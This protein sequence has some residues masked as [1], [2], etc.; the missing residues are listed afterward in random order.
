MATQSKV[1]LADQLR[2][3][4]AGIKA[5]LTDV[6]NMIVGGTTMT[7]ADV[8]AKID[9]FLA[10]QTNTVNTKNGY[11]AA[12]VAEQASN[13]A[14]RTFRTQL[15]GYVVLRY[16]KANPILSQFGF[17][18]LKAKKTTTAVKAVAVLKVKA[19]RA[20]RHTMGKVQKK[21]IKGV[22]DPSVAEALAAVAAAAKAGEATDMQLTTTSGGAAEGQQGTAAPIVATPALAVAAHPAMPAPA[23]APAA[24]VPVA[25]TSAPTGEV[26][27]GG[28]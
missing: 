2:T 15:E 23:A 13:V 25:S 12:V 6:Q 19:T 24:P 16:G 17:T 22:I 7:I 5:N 10:A 14:A 1:T 8:T 27:S 28:K 20:A 9:S 3:L 26:A 18:P 21:Q 11:H 4:E